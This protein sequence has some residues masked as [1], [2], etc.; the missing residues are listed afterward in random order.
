MLDKYEVGVPKKFVNHIYEI[1]YK[2]F[3]LTTGGVFCFPSHLI[4]SIL[5]FLSSYNIFKIF[6]YNL[7][8]LIISLLSHFA[9][10]RPTYTHT[11]VYIRFD[12]IYGYISPII[13]N[14]IFLFLRIKKWVF[15]I[16]FMFGIC[17]PFIKISGAHMIRNIT[18]NLI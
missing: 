3:C 13:I 18:I 12:D 16:K 2:I 11:F 7:I 10:P 9:P 15:N 8:V 14:Q 1:F 6:V 5:F 4:S 17:N